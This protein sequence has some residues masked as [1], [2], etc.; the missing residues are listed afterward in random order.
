MALE[1][2]TTKLKPVAKDGRGPCY[3]MYFD[4]G[5]PLGQQSISV[6]SPE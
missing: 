6:A 2:V 3:G 5:L 1:T 4:C